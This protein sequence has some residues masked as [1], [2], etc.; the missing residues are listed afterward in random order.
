MN[1]SFFKSNTI[2]QNHLAFKET[3]KM[4]FFLI[5]MKLF[6]F[7]LA[8]K[9]LFRILAIGMI[10]FVSLGSEIY[11]QMLKSPWE[12]IGNP[13]LPGA[14]MNIMPQKYQV[15]KLDIES[16][17]KRLATLDTKSP[18]STISS[19]IV[20][21]LPMPNGSLQRF[22]VS[23]SSMMSLNL[24]DQFPNIK[25]Y[26]VVGVDDAGARGKLD[27][28]SWGFHGMVRSV[29]G[30]F[31][32]D[33]YTL[34]D[35]VHYLSYFT[36]DFVKDSGVS[37]DEKSFH[38]VSNDVKKYLPGIVS[39]PADVCSNAGLRSYRLAIACTGEYAKAATGLA[40]PTLEQVFSAIL[41]SINRVNGVYESELG[42]RLVL[43]DKET[44][45]LFTDP[46]SDPYPGTP[47][48]WTVYNLSQDVL[49]QYVGNKQYDIG[50]TLHNQGGGLASI[51]SVC[52]REE[53]GRV[54][55]GLKAPK[56]DPFDIDYLCHEI[57][58]QFGATHTFSVSSG[59]CNG[60]IHEGTRMEPGGGVSIMSYSGLC[61]PNNIAKHSIEYF[62]SV[63]RAQ[64]D[65]YINT[66]S[67]SICPILS[68][69][70]NQAPV[71]STANSIRV[72]KY[73]AF[74]LSGSA[75]DPDG[76]ILNFQWEEVDEAGTNDWTI[77]QSPYF[78]SLVPTSDP[79]R[80]FPSDSAI[81]SGDYSSKMG[82]I[83]PSR[84]Q[85]LHFKL[86]A[87]DGKVGGICESPTTVSVENLGPLRMS[88][89]NQ[90]G[91]FLP[92]NTKQLITW[93]VNDID[94]EPLN[95]T[96]V[97]LLLSIDGGKTY[98]SLVNMVPNDGMEEIVL[99]DF[100]KTQHACRIK[101]ESSD[102]TFFDINDANFTITL[103]SS[104][105]VGDDLL[106]TLSP[107]PASENVLV[108]VS[109]IIPDVFTQFYI[110]DITGRLLRKEE[111]GGN[112]YFQRSYNLL[113]LGK[114]LY[115]VEVSNPKQKQVCR[116]LKE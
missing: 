46:A 39:R 11:A 98:S 50:H 81:L 113:A 70:D 103:D 20:L 84:S 77:G 8:P 107:N 41:T 76:D 40:R 104:G 9:I 92:R 19:E 1:L 112:D 16:F 114:G 48:M 12:G 36:S 99:P 14:K 30:D 34:G 44:S 3:N 37:F 47:D 97:N 59:A 43:I 33:P 89:F 28:T 21:E 87:R 105:Y 106:I 26:D 17:K 83:V 69:I 60:N 25:T 32:I 35:S 116:F 74:K 88:S 78:R 108:S 71:V 45:V 111:I 10:W 49:D 73:T 72:P 2:K 56:G 23:E 64:I 62:H 61:S 13:L 102:Q 95:C 57:G 4:L 80:S 27:W 68:V 24:A 94:K 29:S 22:K 85:I 31:F 42:I 53:K 52:K 58:H 115:V 100:S 15:F 109:G 93:E 55:T 51:S 6:C 67:G 101:I 110:Y 82:D 18:Y 66:D 75:I 5:Y 63:S 54:V 7:G 79:W 86:I 96:F 38:T 65:A 91:V 90:S